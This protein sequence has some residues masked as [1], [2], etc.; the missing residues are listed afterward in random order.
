MEVMVIQDGAIHIASS[1]YTVF[2]GCLGASYM[3]CLKIITNRFE[4]KYITLQDTHAASLT[5]IEAA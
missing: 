2:V 3:I 5:D 1:A 4:S